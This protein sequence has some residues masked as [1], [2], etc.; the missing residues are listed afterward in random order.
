MLL[1]L[2]PLQLLKPAGKKGWPTFDP[3]ATRTSTMARLCAAARCSMARSTFSGTPVAIRAL[4][5]LC[6]TCN[7]SRMVRYGTA[8]VT[9]T[10]RCVRMSTSNKATMAVAQL[11]TVVHSC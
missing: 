6:T 4:T 8:L 7:Q 10:Y 9:H 2:L 11:L 3:A 5:W 1:R